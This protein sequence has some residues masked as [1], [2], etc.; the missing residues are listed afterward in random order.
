MVTFTM[1]EDLR[2]L[3]EKY[4][5]GEFDDNSLWLAD[6]ATIIAKDK[7]SLL[8]LLD[9]LEKTGEK[10]GLELSQ[11]KTKIMRIRG[12]DV[13]EKIGKYNVVRE[14]N[15]LGIQIG[16]RGRN[17]FEAENKKLIKKARKKVNALLAQIKKSADKIIVGKAIWKL[18]AIPSILYGR[19]VITTS[20][21]NIELL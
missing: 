19:A 12:P 8:R 11:E 17:I 13:G 16:G 21:N 3:A 15:Y 14:V 5:I 18:M 2:S 9:V 7:P 10:N 4:K 1:I 20:K 6:D